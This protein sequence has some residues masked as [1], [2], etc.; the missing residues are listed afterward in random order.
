MF[1]GGGD[2]MNEGKLPGCLLMFVVIGIVGVGIFF[3]ARFLIGSVANVNA[4]TLN[5]IAVLIGLA[6]IISTSWLINHE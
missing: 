5:S 2:Q 4:D 1:V 3:L 6:A